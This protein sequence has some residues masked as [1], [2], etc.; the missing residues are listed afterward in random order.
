MKAL[1]PVLLIAAAGGAGWICY[2][3]SAPTYVPPSEPQVAYAPAPSV[4][5]RA[6]AQGEAAVLLD[7]HGMCCTS[8]TGKLHARLMEQPGVHVAAVDFDAGTASAVVD[9]TVEPAALAAALTFD[10]YSA[11]PH[12]SP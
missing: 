5:T 4:L 7:V 3:R 8:C 11:Q 2:T 9:A 6:P 1:L 10:K 12:A